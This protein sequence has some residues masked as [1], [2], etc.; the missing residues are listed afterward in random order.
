EDFGTP[1]EGV[2][3]AVPLFISE[4]SSTDKRRSIF[5][6]DY[7]AYVYSRFAHHQGP[8]VVFGHSLDPSF[9][10][11]ILDAMKASQNRVAGISIFPGVATADRPIRGIKAEWQAKLPAFTL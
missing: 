6:S 8:I 4:G 11:H 7:L 5:G 9:D 1:I 2:P 3:D 10:N